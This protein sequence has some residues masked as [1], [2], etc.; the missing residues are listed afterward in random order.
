[1]RLALNN[2]Q[3]LICHKIE[4]NQNKPYCTLATTPWVSSPT[5]MCPCVKVNILANYNHSFIYHQADRYTCSK[6][7]ITINN[8][9]GIVITGNDFL[10]TTDRK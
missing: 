9:T 3:W 2:L 1:M 7:I 10:T 5:H 8:Q 6:V 4:P